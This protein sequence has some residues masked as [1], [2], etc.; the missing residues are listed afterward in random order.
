MIQT[1]LDDLLAGIQ[2]ARAVIF[3]DGDGEAIAQAGNAE[4]DL[5]LQGAW[6]EIHLDHIKEIT[7]RLGLGSVR[8]V[9]FSLDEGNELIVPVKD[10]Y[11]LLLF[12]SALAGPLEA[13]IHLKK[14]V[15]LL[16]QDIG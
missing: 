15:E 14:A 3:L 11:C 16:K 10:E 9:L 7:Q 2:G 4:A 12:L 5:K 1:I 8:A 6:K 13:M